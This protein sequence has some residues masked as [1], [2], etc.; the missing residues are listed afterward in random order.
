MKTKLKS[1]KALNKRFKVLSKGKNL[2][3]WHSNTSHLAY[4]K[5]NKQ[6]RHLKKSSLVNKTDWKR[7]RKMII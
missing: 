7:L 2:K 5:S 4:S 1:K 3:H 6:R